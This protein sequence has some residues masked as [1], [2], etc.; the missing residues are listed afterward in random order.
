MAAAPAI[1]SHHRALIRTLRAMRFLASFSFGSVAAVRILQLEAVGV[2]PVQIGSL[3]AAYSVLVAVVEI[4]SGAVAD[5]RGRRRTKILASGVMVAALAVFAL[6]GD[7][8]TAALALGL[9]GIGRALTSGTI[10]SWFVD[11][12]GDP[13]NPAVL[14]GIASAEAA[15]NIG[16]ALGAVVGGLLPWL[17]AG[18]VSDIRVFGPVFFVA[19]LAVIAEVV[20]T[21]R[22]MKE[23]AVSNAGELGGVWRTTVKGIRGTLNARVPRWAAAVFATYGALNAC[24]ELLTPQEFSAN[25]TVDRAALFFG[26]LVAVA[27]LIS[28]YTATRTPLIEQWAGSAARAAGLGTVAV[29]ILALPAALSSWLGAGAA[30]VG[31]NTVGGPLLPLLATIVHRHVSSSHRSTAMSTLNLSFMGGATLGSVLVA[32]IER[33]A[34]LIVAVAAVGCGWGL[35][36]AQHASARPV[37]VVP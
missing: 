16:T 32:A 29:V 9:L 24:M 19:G 12:I 36:R 25:F 14:A 27:W 26:L 2:S 34:V 17:F 21:V 15:H 6:A 23:T 7:V 37:E 22:G 33:S 11:E 1:D 5:V 8:V 3:M 13:H 35:L 4:P 20:V 10:E 18:S 30:Y 28:A 31:L